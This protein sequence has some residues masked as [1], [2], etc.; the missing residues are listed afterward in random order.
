MGATE[1]N[2]IGRQASARAAKGGGEASAAIE[3]EQANAV[4]FS[5]FGRVIAQATDVTGSVNGYGADGVFKGVVGS[6]LHGFVGDDNADGALGINDGRDR[7]FSDNFEF[8]YGFD[9]A[10]YDGA[11][12]S[13]RANNTV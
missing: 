7:G 12:I 4:A 9:I 10:A 13:R 3:H 6:H 5:R 8:A 1:G 2:G 11:N